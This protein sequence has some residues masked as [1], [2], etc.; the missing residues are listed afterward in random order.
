MAIVQ[1]QQVWQQQQQQQHLHA[2]KDVDKDDADLGVDLTALFD[3][4]HA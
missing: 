1:H 3:Q 4:R 2:I